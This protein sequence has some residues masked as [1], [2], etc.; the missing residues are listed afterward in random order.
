MAGKNKGL[1]KHTFD[2]WVSTVLELKDPEMQIIGLLLPFT[3]LRVKEFIHLHGP[4]WLSWKGDGS[5]TAY[6]D[7]PVIEVPSRANCFRRGANGPCDM[8]E[9]NDGGRFETKYDDERTIP[10]VNS[11]KNHGATGEEK[12]VEQELPLRELTKTYFKVSRAD[13]GNELIGGKGLASTTVN[14]KLKQIGQKAKLDFERE[15]IES[16]YPCFDKPIP[17]IDPHDM[18]G[19]FVMQL[20]RNNMQRTKV[21]G[22]TGHDHVSSLA[23]YEER[24][25]K[26]IDAKEFLDHI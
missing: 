21:I 19:T 11:W 14:K 4:T 3:G 23:P 7:I 10:L 26:E 22:Y 1:F 16:H 12:F 13:V 25:A 2:Q 6:G 5:D 20:M 9:S 17:N 24:L 15:L 18:R 8:C